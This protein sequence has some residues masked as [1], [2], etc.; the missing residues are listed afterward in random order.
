MNLLD[1]SVKINTMIALYGSRIVCKIRSLILSSPNTNFESVIDDL[2]SRL[3][4][5]DINNIPLDGI[6]LTNGDDDS[7][8]EGGY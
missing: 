8:G 6:G 5:A 1:A 3:I 7:G 4:A 2:E